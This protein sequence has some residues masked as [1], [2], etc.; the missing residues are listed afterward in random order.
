[1]ASVVAGMAVEAEAPLVVVGIVAVLSDA[2]PLAVA[3]SAVEAQV[4]ESQ[5]AVA[6]VG[7]TDS[8]AAVAR[9]AGVLAVA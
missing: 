6:L 2:E 3:Q 8:V 7:C 5:V 4:A 9:L 1:M